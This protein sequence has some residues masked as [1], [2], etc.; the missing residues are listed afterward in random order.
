[1][2]LSDGSVAHAG[3]FDINSETTRE[4]VIDGL[5]QTLMAG[6]IS[7]Q[8]PAWGEPHNWRQIGKGLNRDPEGFG[9]ARHN[10]AMFLLT[11]GSVRFISNKVDLRVLEAMSTRDGEDRP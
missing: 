11:D 7:H 4:D 10:G 9:N 8:Y 6:E 2:R 5:S 3:V 1:M